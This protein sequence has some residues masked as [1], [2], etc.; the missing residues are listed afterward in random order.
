MAN[1]LYTDPKKAKEVIDKCDVCYIGM[2]DPDNKPY[3]LPFNFG[4]EDDIVYLHSAPIGKKIDVLKN[5]P[6]ICVTFSTD[7]ML[8]HRHEQV[9]C[10]Y[11][12]RYKSV[13]ISG[14]VE[15]I[16]DYDEKVRV[17]NIIMRKYTGKNFDYN[18]PAVKNVAIYKVIPEKTE[19]KFS[20][21]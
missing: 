6:E 9:A 20:G 10:S 1:T 13:L 3:V 7:H 21:Y 19:T 2:I 12:M 18:T 14:K 15:F 11:G 17:L 8:F 5:N 16:E 4:Y